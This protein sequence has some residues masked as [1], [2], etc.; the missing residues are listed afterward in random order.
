MADIVHTIGRPPNHWFYIPPVYDSDDPG[1]DLTRRPLPYIDTTLAQALTFVTTPLSQPNGTTYQPWVT[2]NP[3][4]TALVIIDMQNF[5][6]SPALGRDS[7]GPGHKAMKVLEELVPCCRAT[8]MQIIWCNWG[9]TDED[10]EEMPPAQLKGFGGLNAFKREEGEETPNIEGEKILDVKPSRIYRGFGTP[11]GEI[12]LETGEGVD[13]GR[14]LMRD[15]WNSALPPM[16]DAI[17]QEGAAS[18]KRPD[19]WIHKNRM[20][21]AWNPQTPLQEYLKSTG[22]RTLLFGGVNTDQCVQGTLVDA[23]NSG[24]DIVLVKDACGT[25]TP[26]GKE[27][28]EWNAGRSWGFLT[29]SDQIMQGIDTMLRARWA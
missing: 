3:D 26:G 29:D 4:L 15:Q 21:G 8:G 2:L 14:L 22:I 10:I 23:Y 11:M 17:Y 5:F 20:S 19:V 7:T 18:P 16:L 1:F 12:T 24:W 13:A 28:T 25:G 6:L 9:L 27:V